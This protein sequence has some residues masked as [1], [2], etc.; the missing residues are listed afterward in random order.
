[1]D[2]D[3]GV[4]R[5]SMI[6]SQLKP[7]E[8]NDPAIL[9]AFDAVPRELFVPKV[10]RGIAYVDEDIEVASGRFLLEPVVFGRLLVAAKIKP[11][12]LVL[13]IGAL[14][15][16]STAIL[17]HLASAVVGIEEDAALVEKAESR[18]GELEVINTAIVEGP[19]N[20][21]KAD[22]GPYDVI[23][24]EGAVDDVPQALL[25]QLK[26]GGRLLTVRR[27]GMQ[28]RAHMITR[29]GDVFAARD[30]FDANSMGLPGFAKARAFTF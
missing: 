18:L 25:D 2:M 20:A 13:D 7:N 1:M 19:L 24:I 30:L 16:Y 15:G 23:F 14:T 11:T 29:N 5:R 17:A 10:K 12:D 9:D 3:L 28:G 26:D 27:D 21:G 6:N 22:Q 8:V 4:A